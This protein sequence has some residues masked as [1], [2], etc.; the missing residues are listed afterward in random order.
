M[1]Y[2]DLAAEV[3]KLLENGEW[4]ER[5]NK[6]ADKLI[7]N[8]GKFKN[9][10]KKF[11][12]K[13]PL[14][15]YT[16]VSMSMGGSL[17]YDLRF[18]GQSI[19]IIGVNN[20][21]KVFI[22]TKK[23]DESN[24]KYLE[25]DIKLDNNDWLSA[26]A[27]KFRKH[28]YDNSSLKGKSPEHSMENK[29][30]AE[31]KK[32]RSENKKLC[33]IQPVRLFDDLFFQMPTPLTASKDVKYSGANGGGIDIL[34]RVKH[35]NNETRLCVMELKDEYSNSEPPKKVMEQAVAYATFVAHLLRSKSGNKWY[36]L[37]GYK[38]HVPKQLTID[39]ATLMP[40]PKESIP[41]ENFGEEID[42]FSDT[43]LKLYSLY[44]TEENFIGSLKEDMLPHK[45][46][47]L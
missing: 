19:A 26:N 44:F 20:D 14:Y 17:E 28:F 10:Y 16:N 2:S 9:G 12:V 37:F 31:F 5:Y 42:V 11:K 23:K 33:N 27:T 15:A 8:E 38:D 39:V 30:L 7:K 34:S 35:K 25:I 32:N 24:K 22:S 6:Y 13:S 46:N 29:L 43:T 18:S 41:L 36:K 21:G 40:K 3:S 47:L 1:N 45:K 4:I